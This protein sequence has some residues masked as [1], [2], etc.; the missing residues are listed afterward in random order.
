MNRTHYTQKRD[1][2]GIVIIV[3]FALLMAVPYLVMAWS[4]S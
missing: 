1:W 2:D 4:K 3:G